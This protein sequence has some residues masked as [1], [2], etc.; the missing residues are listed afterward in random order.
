MRV[1][2]L[3]AVILLTGCLPPG[4]KAKSAPGYPMDNGDRQPGIECAVGLAW[5]PELGC[6]DEAANLEIWHHDRMGDS[7]VLLDA[8]YALDG[9]PVAR[10]DA[11]SGD[12]PGHK[13]IPIGRLRVIPGSHQFGVAAHYRGHGAG[14]FSYLNGYRFGLSSSYAFTLEGTPRQIVVVATEQGDAT[15]PLERRLALRY[16]LF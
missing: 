13:D 14:V 12:G 1:C 2:S 3:T 15:T 10:F 7:F 11:P 9:Y 4:D 5:H 6:L 16:E 8:T